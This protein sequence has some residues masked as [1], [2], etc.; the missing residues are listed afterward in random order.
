MK[1]ILEPTIDIDDIYEE[2]G[3]KNF[4]FMQMA[5]N[6]SYQL[7]SLDREALFF[8]QVDI[9]AHYESGD[10]FRMQQVIHLRNLILKMNEFGY[11]DHILVYIHW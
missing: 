10:L 8:C 4:P 9:D 5:E 6:G 2:M 7:V 1:I 11:C 3:T